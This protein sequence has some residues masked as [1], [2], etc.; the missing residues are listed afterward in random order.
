[1]NGTVIAPT[2]QAS[3]SDLAV[4]INE[5]HHLCETAMNGGL[6]HALEAGRLLLEAKKQCQ[7]GTWL[8]WLKKTFQ[9]SKRTA[10]AYLRLHREYPQLKQKTQRVALLSFRQAIVNVA[11][12]VQIVAKSA[13]PHKVIDVWEKE[14]CHNARRAA[15]RAEVNRTTHEPRWS[16][17][18]ETRTSA[19]LTIVEKRTYDVDCVEDEAQ[20]LCK[21]L[22]DYFA[23]WP[24][25]CWEIKR[26]VM[27]RAA[28]HTENPRR[29]EGRVIHQ[30]EAYSRESHPGRPLR[31]SVW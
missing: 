9:G 19:P 8:P 24:V 1:M 29:V 26:L 18:P 25:E 4:Q 14:Q 6:Q 2:R 27:W 23:E 22:S 11:N 10:Q 20:Q 13:N 21:Q 31:E 12:D 7:H 3:L 16:S 17:P 15:A 5:R 28:C 30:A